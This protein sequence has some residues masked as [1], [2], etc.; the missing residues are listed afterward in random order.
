MRPASCDKRERK[1]KNTTMLKKNYE[2]RR[3]LTKGK[4]YGSMYI[5]AYILDNNRSGN[6]LGIA[7]S[8]KIA[9]SVNRNKIKRLI[10]ENY[11]LM[12]DNMMMGKSMVILWK[13]NAS[14]DKATFYNVKEDITHILGK[15][16]LL[17]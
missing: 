3:V 10:R 2:F 14:I 7:I 5:E 11:R 6:K 13:K 16:N 17:K 12:E 1:M 15:A 8:K 4:Y 9:N